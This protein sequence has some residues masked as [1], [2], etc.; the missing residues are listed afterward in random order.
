MILWERLEESYL[1]GLSYLDTSRGVSS[2][3]EKLPYG[4]QEKWT[5]YG[6]KVKLENNVTIPPFWVFANFIHREAKVRTDPSLNLFSSHAA[7]VRRDKQDRHGK[8]I[9][10]HKTQVSSTENTGDQKK[11]VDLNKHRPIHNKP[12]QLKKCRG[13]REKFLEDP[14]TVP[15]R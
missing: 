13:F 8:T 12:H 3:I 7:P 1:L 5:S 11:P 14:Q 10:V 2:I 9:S 15:Q 4:L 6:S